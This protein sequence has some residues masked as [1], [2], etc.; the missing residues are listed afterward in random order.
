[1]LILVLFLINN[2]VVELQLDSEVSSSLC[3]VVSD[4]K[5]VSCAMD[6]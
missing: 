5:C 4:S 2:N 6:H 1:M 3:T